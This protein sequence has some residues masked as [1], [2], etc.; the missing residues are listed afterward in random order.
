MLK[1]SSKCMEN[2]MLEMVMAYISNCNVEQSSY[3]PYNSWILSPR[4]LHN[5]SRL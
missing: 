4:D 1:T 2:I 5:L 3:Y